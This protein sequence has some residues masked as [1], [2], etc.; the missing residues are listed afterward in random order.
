MFGV[1]K[2]QTTINPESP[3]PK[4]AQT[5]TADAVAKLAK[6]DGVHVCS[7]SLY[8]QV[9]NG[10]AS[11]IHRYQIEGR[12][13][14]MGLGAYVAGPGQLN[15]VRATVARHKLSGVD[16]LGAKQAPVGVTFAQVA[17]QCIAAHGAGW[18]AK[19][20]HDF[21][22]S[23][24]AYALPVIGDLKVSAIDTPQAL[25]VLSPIWA[26]KTVTASRLRN[27]CELIIDFAH[28]LKLRTGE[29][30][31]RWK[32]GLKSM[33]AAPTKLHTVEHYATLPAADIPA[34]MERLAQRKPMRAR[35]LRFLVLTVARTSNVVNA[36]WG[37]IDGHTWN[38]AA[39][40]MKNGQ[41]WRCPLS[42]QAL[43]LIERPAT[44][45]DSDYV[46]PGRLG[47]VRD[48]DCMRA[49]LRCL[50]YSCD[51][52][53]MRASFRSWCQEKNV[54]HEAAEFQLAHNENSKTVQSYARS[55]LLEQRRAVMTQWADACTTAPVGDN[56]IQLRG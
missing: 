37:Q 19:H 44:A 32:G 36:T 7:P 6:I 26:E 12:A 40:M 54:S 8:L 17:E 21:R 52:H 14:S 3:M 47:Q 25:A 38:V 41:P 9:Q 5:L 27:R 45:Q 55:D 50:G 23:L 49:E 18:S 24:A 20:L 11:W 4:I 35:M 48:G 42:R 10:R 1:R 2:R 43:A 34:L 16:P 46:F 39:G 31:F 53:G 33:L 51:C 22:A 15:D 13:R 56:V 30:P 29:N 28:G